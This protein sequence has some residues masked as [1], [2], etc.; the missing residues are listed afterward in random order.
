MTKGVSC[1]VYDFKM[2]LLLKI[3]C[4]VWCEF[5]RWLKLSGSGF[6]YSQWFPI[7]RVAENGSVR[8]SFPDNDSVVI[9]SFDSVI[10]G[11]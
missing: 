10:R 3:E 7:V 6:A 9:D 4:F 8:R 11:E 2:A 5:K 1:N